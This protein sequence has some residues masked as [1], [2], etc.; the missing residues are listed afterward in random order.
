MEPTTSE[1]EIK[2]IK[3]YSYMS[4]SIEVHSPSGKVTGLRYYK[5]WDAI[6][7]KVCTFFIDL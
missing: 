1:G 2:R 5:T 6:E 3:Q 4:E 7:K